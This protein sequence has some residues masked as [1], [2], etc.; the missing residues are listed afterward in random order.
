M[1]E[2]LWTGKTKR[3]AADRS[4]WKQTPNPTVQQAVIKGCRAPRRSCLS[5]TPTSKVA[6]GNNVKGASLQGQ[7]GASIKETKETLQIAESSLFKGRD[8][9]SPS[10]LCLKDCR[11]ATEQYPLVSAIFPSMKEG[12]DGKQ[13]VAWKHNTLHQEQ[14][15]CV[16]SSQVTGQ[17][18]VV[19]QFLI[20]VQ[21]SETPRT[22]KYWVGRSVPPVFK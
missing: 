22:K 7:S 9:M 15:A 17:S 19:V 2:W 12:V 20:H 3:E 18:I 10:N 8:L 16:F 1:T 14:I 13:P 5:I 4:K 11:I 21:L 6:K